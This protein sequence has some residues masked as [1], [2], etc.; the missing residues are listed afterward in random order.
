[1]AGSLDGRLLDGAVVRWLGGTGLV[2]L[3]TGWFVMGCAVLVSGVL[4]R[5]DGA[6]LMV[7][8]CV[9][10]GAGYLSWQFLLVIAAMIIV[11]AGLGLAWTAWR[12]AP[13]GQ[14]P[15]DDPT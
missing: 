8:V 14:V 7:G 11:A 10:V 12:L 1:V 5:V 2:L 4:N 3:A 15:D 6:L 9:A 13:D